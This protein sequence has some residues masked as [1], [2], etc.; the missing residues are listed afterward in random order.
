MDENLADLVTAADA[1]L[2]R[3]SKRMGGAIKNGRVDVGYGIDGVDMV[4]GEVVFQIYITETVGMTVADKV[5]VS[6]QL[7]ATCARYWNEPQTSEDGLEIDLMFSAK[8]IDNRIV[9]SAEKI[10]TTNALLVHLTDEF[11]KAYDK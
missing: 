5:V 7:K 8:S 1:A 6:S 10:G 4:L 11:I 3:E 9:L 2:Y